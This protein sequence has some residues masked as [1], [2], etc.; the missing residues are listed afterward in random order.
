MAES[1]LYVTVKPGKDNTL[2]RYTLRNLLPLTNQVP[3]TSFYHLFVYS[4]M[5]VCQRIRALIE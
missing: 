4:I 1:H 3:H 5:I 2:L